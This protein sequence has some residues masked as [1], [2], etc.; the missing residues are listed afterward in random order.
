M[1]LP[2]ILHRSL[3]P[4]H[5]APL[6]PGIL[7]GALALALGATA[8]QAQS[9]EQRAEL[10]QYRDSIGAVEDTLALMA[11]ERR[12]M[13]RARQN[14]DDALL[15]L[16]LG[17]LAI[18]LGDRGSKPHYDDAA[19]E[20]Q[21]ATEL[22]PDWPYAWFGLGL[23]EQG[24]GDSQVSIVRGLQN[25]MGKDALS[26]S[27]LAFA[28]SAAVDPAFDQ[29]LVSL[30]EGALRQRINIKLDLALE[31]LRVADTTAAGA[32]PLVQL[33][34]GR[35]ER[36]AGDLEY[37]R[38]AFR[39]YL[40]TGHN[41]SLAE[42]ELARTEFL[43]GRLDA[44]REY[45]A[46]A[47]TDDSV[48]VTNYRYDLSLIASDSELKAF[49]ETDRT[50]RPAFL[51]DYWEAK[52]KQ[53]LRRD[54]ER[55]REHY[56]RLYY[57]RKNFFLVSTNRHYDIEEVYR[58]R[59][60]DFDDRGVVY[61]R[62]GEPTDRATYN[63]VNVYDNESWRYQRPDGDMIFHFIARE[64]VQDYKLVESVFDI[65]GFSAS[66]NLRGGGVVNNQVA[67]ELLDSRDGLSS[68][69]RRIKGAGS[70]SSGRLQ[71][72]ER[73]LGRTSIEWGTTT[74]SYNLQFNRPLKART[75]VLAVGYRGDRSL[76][77]VA[78]AIPG[79]ELSGFDNPRGIVYPVRLRFV[80][81][82][83]GDR[84]VGFVDTTRVFLA[85]QPVP[86]E[87]FLVGE[88]NLPVVPGLLHYRLAL[89]QGE[90][91]GEVL[92]LDSVMVAAVS[93]SRLDLSDPVLGS[94]RTN[95][96]WR[97][98]PIDTVYFNP[99]ARYRQ[100]DLI[101]LYYEVYGLRVGETYQTKLVVKRRGGGGGFLGLFGGGST[102]ISLRF[103]ERATDEVARVQRAIQLKR[104]K[105][106]RYTLELSVSDQSGAVRRRVQDFEVTK[107]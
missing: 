99:D 20:F 79:S 85:H 33:Y 44:T 27:A 75:Q 54:G 28:K 6:G 38:D 24:V 1:P 60:D 32:L 81:L 35:V 43:L 94:R 23:A 107:K 59:Q 4:H 97:P 17:F 62:H 65:M 34:R 41:R 86:D 105:P 21:W 70:G 77:H 31:A 48:T 7:V 87:E 72:E 14:R 98:S 63:G 102:P 47:A 49:D 39:K 55:L 74:D 104:L 22:R 69:Y 71:A 8:A 37:S 84:P 67:V 93:S 11:L 26:R 58:S 19:S 57:A 15:H 103:E 29:G 73:N 50:T 100:D 16:R 96:V 45:L 53:S 88:V 101:Q 25:M 56:R 95:L 13:E 12:T 82:G 51:R 36:A 83:A 90:D 18:Q 3:T 68:L 9:P 92:P 30:A 40:N 91:N 80:G 89:Q 42:L 78:F 61:I 106:G 76:V 52:D 66:V 5:P 46:G 2:G 64:D 10:E